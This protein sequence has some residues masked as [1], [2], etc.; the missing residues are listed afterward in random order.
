MISCWFQT[1][2]TQNCLEQLLCSASWSFYYR[3][4]HF[5]QQP[6]NL[7]LIELQFPIKSVADNS[8]F[9]YMLL[10]Y[11]NYETTLLKLS[12]LIEVTVL[13]PVLVK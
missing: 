4:K 2:W 13:I 9:R 3:E 1:S 11:C 5:I 7:V 8:F 12:V 6:T 10:L